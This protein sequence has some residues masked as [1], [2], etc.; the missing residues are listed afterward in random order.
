M[1]SAR[2][3]QLLRVPFG[4][5]LAT[6]KKEPSVVS[7]LPLL[8]FIALGVF[9]FLTLLAFLTFLAFFAFAS[10]ISIGGA[11]AFAFP[12]VRAFAFTGWRRSFLIRVCPNGRSGGSAITNF[13]N[14][15]TSK[16]CFTSCDRQSCCASEN[17]KDESH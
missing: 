8:A 14:R 17:L 3:K 2:G 1:E 4:G 16:A 12:C 10:H 11:R 7:F 9:A 15:Q 5:T 13:I 6:F